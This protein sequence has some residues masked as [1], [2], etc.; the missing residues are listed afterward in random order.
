MGSDDGNKSSLSSS[1]PLYS[2]IL[3]MMRRTGTG[4]PTRKTTT[5]I[6]SIACLIPVYLLFSAA[7][8]HNWSI[9]DIVRIY[10]SP[11]YQLT[12]TFQRRS[13]MDY[14][15]LPSHCQP[16]AKHFDACQDRYTQQQQQSY[17][18]LGKTYRSYNSPIIVFACHRKWCHSYFGHCEP[19]AGLGDRFRF[20]TSQID[21]VF[22]AATADEGRKIA[23]KGDT[24]CYAQV[25]IDAPMN[26]LLQIE[27]SLYVDPTSWFGEFFHYRSYDVSRRDVLPYDEIRRPQSRH[28]QQRNHYYTHFTPNHYGITNDYNA[29]YFHMIYK[30]DNPLQREIQ[31]HR[32]RLLDSQS[33][34]AAV[35][36]EHSEPGTTK[37][38]IGI[39]YRTGD[40]VAFG[41]P[42]SDARV[43]APELI[44]GWNRMYECSIKFM[45]QL[46]LHHTDDHYENVR[47][48][49]ATDNPTVKEHVRKYHSYGS[50][51]STF[52]ML[53]PF[54]PVYMTDLEPDSY[55]RGNSG[56][57][58]A[59]LELYLLSKCDGIVANAL[60]TSGYNGTAAAISQ[61]AGLA[62]KIGFLPN[63]NFHKCTIH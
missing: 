60:P 58:S 22:S 18:M 25:K 30:P 36:G 40:A 12:K 37:T 53:L 1:S 11:E 31:Y 23:T 16:I 47:F 49:L 54:V 17:M 33:S 43:S 7:T 45:K 2:S 32:H 62:K 56:D 14:D 38:T 42:N 24:S 50:N 21:T 34:P 48:Y 46:L 6:G 9:V 13:S 5:L 19:C 29:C 44:S 27:S 51:S 59:L 26:G 61:F 52:S 55:L 15:Y 10:S 4:L 20:L 39:H 41:I 63:T 28:Q 35:L 8:L 57:R 3:G